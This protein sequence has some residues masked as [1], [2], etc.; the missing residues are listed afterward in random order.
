M[1][2]LSRNERQIAEPEGAFGAI[3]DALEGDI[4]NHFVDGVGVEPGG[5]GK[6]QRLL[7]EQKKAEA[8]FVIDT[9]GEKEQ[10]LFAA[11]RLAEEIKSRAAARLA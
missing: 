6:D 5:D 8:D 1:P 7:V 3:L 10:T 9:S 4:E 2:L 11:D